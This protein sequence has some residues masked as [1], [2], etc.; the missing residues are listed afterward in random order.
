MPN[1][2]LRNGIHRCTGVVLFVLTVVHESY[3]KRL[4]EK[5]VNRYTSLLV[6][7][8]YVKSRLLVKKILFFSFQ[9]G[10]AATARQ[11]EA[12]F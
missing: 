8:A 9:Q 5:E 3:G 12:P 11:T 10:N 6:L 2:I 7:Y 1:S 4:V